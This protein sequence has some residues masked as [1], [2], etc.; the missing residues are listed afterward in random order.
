MNRNSR[1]F[2]LIELLVVI[3]IIAILAAILFP[4]FAQA[5]TAAKRVADLSNMK[6]LGLGVLM[7]Q[8]DYDDLL[9]PDRVVET[10]DGW[11]D[12]SLRRLW[13]DDVYPYVKSGGRAANTAAN[14]NGL[15]NFQGNGGIFQDPLNQAAWSTEWNTIGSTTYPG[16][17]TSRY[18]RS[19]AI[20]KSAGRN[21][22]GAPHDMNLGNGQTRTGD[23][24]DTIWLEIYPDDPYGDAVYNNG[25]NPNI[26]TNAVGTAMLAPTRITWPDLELS[27]TARPGDGMGNETDQFPST[28]S[29]SCSA[30]NGQINFVFF[31]GHAK[32]MNYFQSLANDVWDELSPTTG[33]G[34]ECS[35]AQ[36][37]WGNGPGNGMP[38]P[39]GIAADAHAIGEWNH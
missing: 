18:P 23:C 34:V 13:K 39:Q 26:L 29:Q 11:S 3:A 16:D 25:G 9:P 27:D 24:G 6:Q 30:G 20:N 1:A 32:G 28:Y 33:I 38:W 10:D 5:K 12:P 15:Y 36:V 17:E 4:V 2:T 22:F 14:S 37:G 19:Y 8:N 21:E 7:Y 35:W 31:D